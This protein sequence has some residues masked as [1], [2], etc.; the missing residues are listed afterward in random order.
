[1]RVEVAVELAASEK[2]EIPWETADPADCYFDLREDP[3]TIAR[4]E[5]A[6]RHPPLRNLLVA[7]NS[8]DSL[9]STARCKTWLEQALSGA[10]PCE[11]S[12]HIDL[13]FAAEPFN[14]DRSRYVG[15][16]QRLAELLTRET[17]PDT[18]RAELRVRACHFRGPARDGF[19]LRI[20]LH[21]RAATPEQA[22]V[23]WGFALARVQQALLFAS[24]AIRQQI[25]RAS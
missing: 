16:T 17:A 24:R 13:V 8:D 23:R 9:F 12:S 22:E 25:A 14:F 7:V 3:R 10:D 6:R 1:M 19:C 18:Q 2:L 11:F 15:L 21:A 5:P 4:V 20:V